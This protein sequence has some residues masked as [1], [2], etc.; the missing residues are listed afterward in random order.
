[1]GLGSWLGIL[2]ENAVHAEDQGSVL[3]AGL[4]HILFFFLKIYLFLFYVYVCFACMYVCAPCA[5]LV[6]TEA[7]RGHQIALN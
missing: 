6:P 5:C 4:G 1:M 2:R 7:R 3:S